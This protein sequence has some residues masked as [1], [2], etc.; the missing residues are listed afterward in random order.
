MKRSRLLLWSVAG[1][2]ALFGAFAVS[3]I[4]SSIGAQLPDNWGFRGHTLLAGIAFTIPGAIVA[5]KRPEHRIGWLLLLG[6]A[7]T[8]A[9]GAMQE[10]ATFAF[11]LRPGSFPAATAVA[12]I[13]AWFWLVF[14]GTLLFLLL[15]FP[16]GRLPSSRWRPLAW[17]AAAA[18]GAAMVVFALRPGP[19]ENFAGLDN[20]MAAS[21]A[22]EEARRSGEGV[23][24]GPGLV[25]LLVACASAP[26]VRWRRASTEQRQQ[27]KWFATAAAL[28]AF[29][30]AFMIGSGISKLGQV[31][32]VVSFTTVPIAVGVAVLRYRLYQIDTIINRT[33]VYGALTAILAGSFVA[34]QK[35]MER[36]FQA[37]T[38]ASSDIATI[39]VLFVIASAFAPL[40]TRIQA[41]VD[42]RFRPASQYPRSSGSAGVP[43]GIADSLR[44][45]ARLREEGVI[46]EGDFE[47]KKKELL[48]RI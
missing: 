23:I 32:M 27:L 46:T 34:G 6:G 4:A 33:L 10:Y 17:V 48:A 45:L 11:V 7:T 19:L 25:A 41:A 47:R 12:W 35:L 43:E 36:L 21:G 28:C 29:A 37:T 44:T 15:V 5:A 18:I 1:I 14:F 3:V 24:I 20:P 30:F 42:R 26:V 38:G 22:F 31:A 39:V 13:G 8:T 16:D 40:R 9:S 2:T